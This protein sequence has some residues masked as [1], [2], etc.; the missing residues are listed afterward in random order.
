MVPAADRLAQDP[1]VLA[2]LL[3]DARGPAALALARLGVAVFPAHS[4]DDDLICSCGRDCGRDAAKHPRTRRGLLDATTDPAIV[5]G[6]WRRWAGANPAAATGGA[7]GVWVLDVDP[8]P[9]G[10]N[11]VAALEA[12]HGGIP[13]TWAVETGGG[14]LH[15]WFAHPGSGV[16]TSAGRVGPGLDVR[17]EGAYVV[18]PPA[19]HRAGG[20]YAWAAAWRPGLVPLAPAP[21]WLLALARAAPAGM[22]PPGAPPKGVGVGGN[23][24]GGPIA[25]GR[26]NATLARL[27]GSMRR[28]G[29]GEAA[30]LAALLE[31]NAARCVPPLPE[32]EVSRVA[33]SVARYAPGPALPDPPAPPRSGGF[34]E[35]V[36]GKAV[37]R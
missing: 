14:G 30:I 9:G 36:G 18:V 10:E 3:G 17:G 19:R 26:R 25:E 11:V 1:A 8:G 34:V 2:A 33:H 29:F 20:R 23:H 22:V 27:A 12:E 35:F 21:D 37:V 28:R 31:E 6:W 13:P 15:L 7:S 32:A 24:P 16:P 5:A 4:V